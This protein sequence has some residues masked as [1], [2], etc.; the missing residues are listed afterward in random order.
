MPRISN[1]SQ[2]ANAP[3]VLGSFSH[4]E[5][6]R[7]ATQ[8]TNTILTPR[9]LGLY[10][11]RRKHGRM[12]VYALCSRR[13]MNV[14]VRRRIFWQLCR[15]WNVGV[16]VCGHVN[17]YTT[18]VTDKKYNCLIRVYI[19]STIHIHT[20]PLRPSSPL[21]TPSLFHAPTISP[22]ARRRHPV[23]VQRAWVSA[24]FQ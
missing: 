23:S 15:Q 14:H 22:F 24:M 8:I 12:A 4:W 11:S 17:L 21:D 13:K 18:V 5:Y 3:V 2:V 6:N 1:R 19:H 10:G 7:E 20:A 9:L 16:W